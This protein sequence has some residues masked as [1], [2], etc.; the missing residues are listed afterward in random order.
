MVKVPV[1]NLFIARHSMDFYFLPATRAKPIRGRSY[2]RG[3]SLD[4]Y[5]VD[6]ILLTL[7]REA[8]SAPKSLARCHLIPVRVPGGGLIDYVVTRSAEK[9]SRIRKR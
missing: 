6:L 8:V 4:T 5:T 2:E 3:T 1:R 7:A 9:I